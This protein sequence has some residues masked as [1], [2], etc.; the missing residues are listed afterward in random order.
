MRE[1]PRRSWLPLTLLVLG[2]LLMVSHEAGYLTPVENVFHYVLDPLQRIFSRVV[3]VTGDLFQTIREVRELRTRVEELQTQVDGLTVENVLVLTL[4][5]CKRGGSGCYCAEN[6]MIKR[7][8]DHLL[9]REGEALVIDMEAGIE[10]LSRGTASSVGALITVVEPGMRSVET[11]QRV[12]SLAKDLGIPRHFVVG[13]KIKGDEDRE[14]LEAQLSGYEFLGCLPFDTRLM[15]ADRE[16]RSPF[17]RSPEVM[18]QMEGIITHLMN[19]TK[20]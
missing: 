14:F 12:E 20:T 3:V 19:K 16:G 15:D 6:V 11:A 9:L 10:H 18:T 2:L 17:M 5:R 7:L 4:G 8:I 1:S 13:N